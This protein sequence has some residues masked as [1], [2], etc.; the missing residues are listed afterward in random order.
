MF[1]P[2]AASNPEAAA[3]LA[4]LDCN[5]WLDSAFCPDVAS[6]CKQD[7][8]D[9]V[10]E[11][12]EDTGREV[13]AEG[14]AA[15][16]DHLATECRAW[17]AEIEAENAKPENIAREDVYALSHAARWHLPL[18]ADLRMRREACQVLLARM[19][20]AEAVALRRISARPPADLVRRL[21]CPVMCGE[22]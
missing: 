20:E 17:A 21:A 19:A 11:Y 22:A 4:W 16:A 1:R 3:I 12:I 10:A 13:S 7:A 18:A 6:R 15:L 9:F 2:S 5:D 8:A 14:V